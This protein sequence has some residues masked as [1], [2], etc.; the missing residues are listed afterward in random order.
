MAIIFGLIKLYLL[1]GLVLTGVAFLGFNGQ[2]RE[3]LS[4][5]SA[6]YNIPQPIVYVY[7]VGMIILRWPE[8]VIYKDHTESR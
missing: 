6:E 1:I 3:K 8:I 5:V 2:H 7:I 4:K